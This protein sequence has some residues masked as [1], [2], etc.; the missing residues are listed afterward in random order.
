[1][2]EPSAA[3]RAAE[4]MF[5]EA[6]L[7]ARQ[8]APASSWHASDYLTR[9]SLPQLAACRSRTTGA[10]ASHRNPPAVGRVQLPTPASAQG[11][12]DVVMETGSSRPRKPCTWAL[13][14]GRGECLVAHDHPAVRRAS[15]VTAGRASWPAGAIA[16]PRPPTPGARGVIDEH[17]DSLGCTQHHTRAARISGRSRHG[18]IKRC[19]C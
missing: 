12:M 9:C 15:R 11:D 16:R 4:S 18:G 5:T 2:V 3:S 19:W 6:R 14:P 17:L 10:V 13:F 1:M 7:R 8:T